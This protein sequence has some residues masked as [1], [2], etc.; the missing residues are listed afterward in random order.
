[1]A[2][3]EALRQE[4]IEAGKEVFSRRF[5]EVAA[6]KQDQLVQRFLAFVFSSYSC[7]ASNLTTLIKTDHHSF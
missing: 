5:H 6:H 2:R 4:V 7:R 3:F 1:M